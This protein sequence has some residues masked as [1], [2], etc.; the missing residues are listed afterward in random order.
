MKVGDLI[1]HNLGHLGI[2][3]DVRMLYPR[4]PMSPVDTVKVA[5][6][7]SE[8]DWSHPELRFSVFAIN[9]VVSSAK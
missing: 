4:H 7:D 6:I 3:T 2:V 9:R 5:W 8:P 1:E